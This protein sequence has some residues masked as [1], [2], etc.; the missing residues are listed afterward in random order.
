[1][2]ALV[3]EGATVSVPRRRLLDRIDLRI[4]TG[5]TVAL[6]GPNGSGKTTLLRCILGLQKLSSGQVLFDSFPL[7]RLSARAR[8][9]KIAYLSQHTSIEEAITVLEYVAAGRYRFDESRQKSH[10][11]ARQVLARVGAEE[12]STQIISSLSGGERQR[13]ALAALLAQDARIQLLDEPANHLDP[14]RQA[15]SYALLGE[16]QEQR[17]T[18]VIVTHDINLLGY[19]H[20]PE[21]VR[22]IG[23]SEGRM[24]FDLRYGDAALV[25]A[26]SRLYGVPMQC[27]DLA[28]HRFILPIL[29]LAKGAF[30]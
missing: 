21:R 3:I 19:L 22:V 5:E 24:A 2:S 23:L 15:Q 11:A 28:G 27:A 4:E 6:I 1:M 26:L 29:D 10:A 17:C 14:A 18:M 16:M 20:W 13:I 8:A 7:D 30:G 9:E 12:L 25:E